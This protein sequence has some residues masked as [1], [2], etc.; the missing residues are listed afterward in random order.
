M[1]ESAAGTVQ[2]RQAPNVSILA[3]AIRVSVMREFA[4]IDSAVPKLPFKVPEH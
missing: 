2:H 3:T 1:R 4:A